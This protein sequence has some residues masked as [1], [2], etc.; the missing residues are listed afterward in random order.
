MLN[1]YSV[2]LGAD[3]FGLVCQVSIFPTLESYNVE[4]GIIFLERFL[5]YANSC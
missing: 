1:K 5:R 4:F 2:F 3:H